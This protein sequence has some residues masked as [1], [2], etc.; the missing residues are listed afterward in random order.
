MKGAR[1]GIVLGW[2]FKIIVMLAIL[3]VVSFETGAIIVA[4]VTADRVAI[5]AASE[6]GQ[7]YSSTGSQ[8]KAEDAAKQIAAKE[9]AQVIHFEVIPEGTYVR[10]T[11]RKKA[12]T[13]LVQH[14]GF[15]KRFAT[16]DST[17]SGTVR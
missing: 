5:D 7:V 9:G 13:F 14:I 4:K 12:S 15:L 8:T 2:F 1:G 10:V 11:V 6:A 16:A 3:A 17:H